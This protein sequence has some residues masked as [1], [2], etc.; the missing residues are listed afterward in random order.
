MTFRQFILLTGMITG[1]LCVYRS[2]K[3]QDLTARITLSSDHTDLARV[4]EEIDRQSDFS[5]TYDKGVVGKIK[6]DSIHWTAIP[7]QEVLQ[8]LGR[9]TGMQYSITGNII[10]IKQ[11]PQT[12]VQQHTVSLRGRIVDFGSTQ[13]LEGATVTIVE[14]GQSVMADE[15]GYYTF[16]NVPEGIYRLTVSY[17]GYQQA[18]LPN[19]R[20]RLGREQVLDVKM[21]PAVSLNEV[22]VLAGPRK[23]KSVAHTT[24]KALLEEIKNSTGSVS[25]I[26]NE[27]I[28][29]TPDRNAAEVVKRISGVTVVDQRFIVVRGMDTRYNLTYLNDN[30]APY[31][32]LYTKAFA[33]DLLPT[34]IIDKILVY[35]SPVANLS[36]EYAGAVIK[37][38]TKEP[39]AVRHFDIGVQLAHRPGSTMTDIMSY[40]G[41]KYDFFGIDDGTR[42]LPAVAPGY[43]GT[44]NSATGMSQA[45]LVSLFSPV[46]AY[47]YTHSLPDM[48]Y[49]A[50][51]YN[52]WRLGKHAW[53]YD[54]TS[55]TFTHETQSQTI[56]HQL[57]N[58][59]NYM[60]DTT[61]F[62]SD[63]I[64]RNTQQS[65]QD[66][67]INI[68]ENLTLK[69]NK[70]HSIELKNFFVNDGQVL[71]Q[72]NITRPNVNPHFD[73]LAGTTPVVSRNIVLSYQQRTLYS[74]NL[75]GQD[76]W[77]SAHAQL[78]WNLGY[79]HMLQN[80]PDQRISNFVSSWSALHGQTPEPDGLVWEAGGSNYSEGDT[81]LGM[82]SRLFIKTNQNTYN[83]SLDYS[84]QITTKFSLKAGTYQLYKTRDVNRRFFRVNRGGLAPDETINQLGSGGWYGDYG[85]SN[86]N[87]INF[88][89]QQL[90]SIWNP[91]NF[92]QYGSGLWLYDVTSP[93]DRYVASEQN[94]SGYL[95]G[96]W[97]LLSKLTLN[98]GLRYEY[99]RIKLAGATLDDPTTGG[100]ISPVNINQPVTSWLPSANLTYRP[101]PQWVVRGGYG[102][103]VDRPDFREITPYT[104][105]DFQN[106][107][108]YQGFPALQSARIDNMDLRLEWYPKS[109][110]Q[111]E[112]FEI[113]GFYKY[114][115]HPIEHIFSQQ[116]AYTDGDD[117]SEITFR[118]AHY[119][120][121]YGV[122]AEVKSNLSF[123]GA[124]IFPNLSLMANGSLI[125]S[126]AWEYLTSGG[127]PLTYGAVKGRPLQGQAPYVVNAGLYYEKPSTGT[128]IGLI[129]NVNGPI[130]YAKSSALP[131]FD[132]ATAE[133]LYPD[134][135]ELPR[136]LLDA[137]ITQRIVKSLQAKFSVQNLLDRPIRQVQDWNYNQKYNPEVQHVNIRGQVYYTG[138]NIFNSYNPGRY[139]ILS[140]TYAF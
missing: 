62:G 116:N 20:V 17:T 36:A 46:L 100:T 33:Y 68:L 88:R 60:S 117:F 37:V 54:L 132:P 32:E 56:Y 135:L 79:S 4:L 59:W 28:V 74:G 101:G 99:D 85:W 21:Q 114:L 42:K 108:T 16:R 81:Y 31:T 115:L 86:L 47:G 41:G 43:L 6:L 30:V 96:D 131:N 70:N 113:G 39:Q 9:R 98:A 18:R 125:H 1:L 34:S 94:N 40:T 71:T 8:E 72:D 90:P 140:F 25:G 13:P 45:Q 126:M 122:E 84:W 66:G 137:S 73:T 44:P 63:N 64:I 123:L 65:L 139:Y 24:Q 2:A 136:S 15:K 102:R 138:D 107:T 27:E 7:L 97:E 10:S 12:Q 11:D 93:V 48:Q 91:A 111:N 75:S 38:Y 133:Q 89:Y 103:T 82:I 76:H 121:V 51:Y 106:Q 127:Q 50:N 130:I 110:E 78:S 57:G 118:N 80:V 5:F 67:K 3:A 58:T 19:V 83:G 29:R 14:L 119:A 92:P 95:M 69:F 129:Y 128:K 134:I 104:D 77:N 120:K 112:V 55:A 49:Y 61:N 23:V 105:F 26:S 52:G 109:I 22:V 87:I 35:K 53:L 124:G